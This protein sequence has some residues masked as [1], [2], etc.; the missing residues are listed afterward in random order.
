MKMNLTINPQVSSILTM[1]R[2]SQVLCDSGISVS[3]LDADIFFVHKVIILTC[4]IP[5]LGSIGML[6]GMFLSVHHFPVSPRIFTMYSC[7]GMNI[8][9]LECSSLIPRNIYVFHQLVS[10][11][12]ESYYYYFLKRLLESYW[13]H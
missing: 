1:Q 7:C 9:W 6:L 4:T 10:N 11:L 5:L 3:L 12:L 2:Q 13:L 8:P